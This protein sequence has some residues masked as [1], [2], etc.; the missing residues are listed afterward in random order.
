MNNFEK[1]YL[2]STEIEKNMGLHWYADQHNYLRDM[3]GHFDI[4]LD[5]VCGITAALSPLIS[6]QLNV[7]LTYHILRFKGKLPSNIK[8]S[9]FPLNL[10]KAIKIYK[11]K[12]IYPSLRGPKVIQFYLNLLNPFDD[13]SITIDTFMIACYYDIKNRD[14]T[15]KYSTEKE[16]EFLKSEIKK[17][18][19]KYNLLPLQFQAIVWLT[20]HRIIRSMG[21]YN[22]QLTLK[23]F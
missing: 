7:N 21:S 19:E 20:Y 2:Q 12:K 3:G 13:N 22:S 23:I 18:S 17:L 16:I 9:C 4:P 6:W 1:V 15:R 14:D 10:K 11:S 8:T 5:V